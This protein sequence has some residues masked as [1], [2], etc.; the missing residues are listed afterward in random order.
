MFVKRVLHV[1]PLIIPDIYPFFSTDTNIWISVYL[2]IGTLEY[3]IVQVTKFGE[4]LILNL[5]VIVKMCKQWFAEQAENII[6]G[7]RAY[8]ENVH[9]I[10]LSFCEGKL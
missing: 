6:T 8:I 9:V 4:I 10:I 7:S 2:N 3:L 1:D 5:P